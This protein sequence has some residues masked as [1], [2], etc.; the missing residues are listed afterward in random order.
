MKTFTIPAPQVPRAIQVAGRLT[1]SP[2]PPYRQAAKRR[3]TS[4]VRAS[5]TLSGGGASPLACSGGHPSNGLPVEGY[6][7]AVAP[8]T[9]TSWRDGVDGVRGGLSM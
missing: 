9:S 5:G 2:P 4:K 1:L 7:V 6:E 3:E 8:E